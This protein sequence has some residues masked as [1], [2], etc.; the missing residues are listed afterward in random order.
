MLVDCSLIGRIG[1]TP[2]VAPYCDQCENTWHENTSTY[3]IDKHKPPFRSIGTTTRA[4]L[5][6]WESIGLSGIGTVSE[7]NP[8]LA[9]SS[10]IYKWTARVL[11]P[12]EPYEPDLTGLF[13]SKNDLA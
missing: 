1:V 11:M 10:N 8:C 4:K 13:C 7:C 6:K 12:G 2:V 9:A 5:R 3:S